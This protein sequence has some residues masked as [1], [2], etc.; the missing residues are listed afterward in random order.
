[1]KI[2]YFKRIKNK[3][4]SRRKKIFIISIFIYICNIFY[5]N[6]ILYRVLRINI[7]NVIYHLKNK[8]TIKA[9]KENEIFLKNLNNKINRKESE[10]KLKINGLTENDENKN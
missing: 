1:M 8:F 10:N 7:I 3:N 9:L 6:N 4:V 2:F 5:F